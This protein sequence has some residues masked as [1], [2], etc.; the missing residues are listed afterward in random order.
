MAVDETMHRLYMSVAGGVRVVDTRSQETVGEL[1]FGAGSENAQIA[2]DTI[3]GT[4]VLGD[5]YNE[6]L[7]IINAERPKISGRAGDGIV[8]ESIDYQYQVGG[9]PVGTVTVT[10]GLPDGLALDASGRLEG[11]PT[12]ART[13]RLEMTVSNIF[14]QSS[15]S[16][17]I[18]IGELRG[19]LPTI[20]GSAGTGV[21]G[22]VVDC[23]YEIGGGN[24]VGRCPLLRG[25][26]FPT[27][28]P[29]MPRAASPVSRRRRGLSLSS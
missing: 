29:S 4:V 9:D 21:V 6:T 16:D 15:H 22:E 13:Y 11:T 27:A 2:V 18:R 7:R 25:R 14:G 17:T 23:Q 19:E 5:K 24:L 26:C 12:A 1:V 8:G 10:G 20:S 28:S 3:H